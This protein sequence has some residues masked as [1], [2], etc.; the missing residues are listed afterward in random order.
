MWENLMYG[1]FL[2]S[3]SEKIRM[4]TLTWE[5]IGETREYDICYIIFCNAYVW[6]FDIKII[7]LN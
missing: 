6:K 7:E 1:K 3:K 4:K 2:Q 5:S